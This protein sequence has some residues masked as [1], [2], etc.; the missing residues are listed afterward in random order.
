MATRWS[1]GRARPFDFA[2]P[3]CCHTVLPLLMRV[4]SPGASDTVLTC[5][6]TSLSLALRGRHDGGGG[7]GRSRSLGDRH[8]A[9]LHRH[10]RKK[11]SAWR[12]SS[13]LWRWPV[14]LY[15]R[16]LRRVSDRAVRPQRTLPHPRAPASRQRCP[17][18]LVRR[19]RRSL[20]RGARWQDL[21]RFQSGEVDCQCVGESDEIARRGNLHRTRRHG[22]KR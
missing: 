4:E 20:P 13:R 10:F 11:L 9:P 18:R 14:Q 6:T 17:P 22:H 16:R 21:S 8:L 5:I 3:P 1:F 19:P 2:S 12:E 15:Q 7:C